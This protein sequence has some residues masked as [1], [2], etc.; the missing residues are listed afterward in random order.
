[1]VE[2][3]GLEPVTPCLQITCQTLI[4]LPFNY[5]RYAQS[6]ITR[7]K[8]ATSA[9]YPQPD[10]S[11]LLKAPGSSAAAGLGSEGL[12]GGGRIQAIHSPT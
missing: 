8:A 5:L 12:S 3:T 11:R 7:K 2:V 10:L 9:T 6:G 1:M 4:L